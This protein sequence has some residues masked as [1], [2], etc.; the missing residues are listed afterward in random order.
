VTWLVEGRDPAPVPAVTV[1]NAAPVIL[2]LAVDDLPG[3]G[4]FQQAA[5]WVSAVRR[6]EVS[7]QRIYSLYLWRHGNQFPRSYA[8]RLPGGTIKERWF[9]RDEIEAWALTHRF[10]NSGGRI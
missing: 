6:A 9:R 5:D 8:V 10:R 1:Q 7:R 4:G 3:W 2:D